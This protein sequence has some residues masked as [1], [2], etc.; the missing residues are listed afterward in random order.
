MPIVSV[1]SSRARRIQ[2]VLLTLIVL[3]SLPLVVG[4]IRNIMRNL[5]HKR[6]VP[7]PAAQEPPVPPYAETV[8]I[9][10]RPAVSVPFAAPD[11][12]P[13]RPSADPET[14]D[15][16]P[17]PRDAIPDEQVLRFFNAA[18][19]Q[20]FLALA[21]DAGLDILDQSDWLHAVRVRVEDK[22][23]FRRLLAK[24]PVPVEQGFNYR[25]RTPEQ[26][27]PPLMPPDMP[28][29]GFGDRALVWLGAPA[30][31]SAW[32][33]GL[34]VALL[35]TGLPPHPA[36]REERIARI[37]LLPD[38]ETEEQD[39]WHGAAVASLLAGA[40]PT[41]SGVAPA[42]SLLSVRVLDNN[43][44]GDT[45]TLAKGIAEA[46]DRG[47]KVVNMALGGY[48]DCAFLKNAVDYAAD[49][50]VLLVA[51]VGNDGISQLLFP[52]RYES[53]LA[54]AGV[55]AQERHLHFSNRGPQVDIAAP[56]IALQSAWEYDEWAYFT[57]TSAAAPLVSGAAAWLRAEN[58][59]LTALET[60]ELLRAYANDVGP[61]GPD[62][63]HGAG[64]LDL[65]RL[66]ERDRPGIFDIAVRPPHLEP[67]PPDAPTLAIAVQ[68]QNT[69][70]EPLPAVEV[71][72]EFDGQ[73]E[74]S[75]FYNVA[76]GQTVTR[77]IH[78]PAARIARSEHVLLDIV[79]S[80]PGLTDTY[81]ANN[82]R[83]ARIALRE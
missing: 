73:T 37:N 33:Q 21:R 76:V 55:D 18:D 11:L 51:A 17:L 10:D 12:E 4:S 61:A 23:A 20:T 9:P 70:T 42:A 79:A 39:A 16:T 48:G 83:T 59:A 52:A 75:L 27:E 24:A 67:A 68:A 25:V 43:G 60:A 28:Y 14:P 13:E 35:D 31:N 69:G 71:R 29:L 40:H 41:L 38:S 2:A 44:H 58:P 74:T 62:P 72:I 53:V 26:S 7:P 30:D 64:I 15:D 6:S 65:R 77:R 78:I 36:L 8:P 34:T 22:Q 45:F 54:V 5:S 1:M 50:D 56:A 46:V 82:R 63:Y 81:P 47:A 57:G 49:N 66:A 32:G 80:L 19:Q 3:F